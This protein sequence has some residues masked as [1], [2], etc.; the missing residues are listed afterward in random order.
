VFSVCYGPLSSKVLRNPYLCAESKKLQLSVQ[1]R[2]VYIVAAEV[3]GSGKE[4]LCE[5]LPLK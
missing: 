2:A 1:I 5:E 4:T 3:T